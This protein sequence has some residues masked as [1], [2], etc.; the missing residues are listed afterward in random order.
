MG[1]KLGAG[2][3]LAVMLL[4]ACGADDDEP[5]VQ[6]DRT[7][8]PSRPAMVE[9]TVTDLGYRATKPGTLPVAD[10]ATA[11]GGVRLPAGHLV[12]VDRSNVADPKKVPAGPVAWV[13]DDPV[14]ELGTLWSDLAERFPDTGLW[15]LIL[16][17]RDDR[18]WDE[19]LDPTMSR[20]PDQLAGIDVE[21]SL[22]GWWTENLPS[23][24][25]LSEPA[26]AKWVDGMLA[27]FGHRF[28][29]LAAAPDAPLRQETRTKVP[30]GSGHLALV[31]VER[32]ADA[33]AV[34]GWTGPLNY[35]ND[36][37]PFTVVLRSWEDRFGAVV[38]GLGFDTLAMVV[39]RPP[40]TGDE[41]IA[42]AAEHYAA[43]PDL[44]QQG[45]DT[46]ENYASM[47]Q[48]QPSWGFW[49]D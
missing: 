29:G 46:I 18:W 17:R 6:L 1:R 22:A 21:A 11:V 47:L 45:A 19:A 34:L 16:E 4:A 33:P 26:S 24:E 8:R 12:D 9:V 39:R 10:D 7:V 25:E 27:P 20:Q 30:A 37:G 35:Y 5:D 2:L 41:T 23:A 36:V 13:S 28:P 15:P 14:E 40:T 3:A 48:D 49:W 43:C 32:P 38:V 44:V 42:V 31:P